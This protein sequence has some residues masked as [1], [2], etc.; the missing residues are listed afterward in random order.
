MATTDL[1]HLDGAEARLLNALD[2]L[3][4]T[5]TGARTRAGSNFFFFLFLFVSNCYHR[6]EACRSPGKTPRNANAL[7]YR[8]GRSFLRGGAEPGVVCE[9]PL[10][11]NQAILT[12]AE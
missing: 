12:Q 11:R 4:S 7:C 2:A 1:T 6:F 3:H 10:Q 5:G 8:D 9:Q